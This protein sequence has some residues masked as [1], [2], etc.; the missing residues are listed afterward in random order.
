MP[1]YVW[2]NAAGQTLLRFAPRDHGRS[3]W[4]ESNMVTRPR[5]EAAL[6]E[7]VAEFPNVRVLR[8][9]EAVD[10]RP[11]PHQ[12]APAGQVAV[13]GRVRTADGRTA[14]LD[15]VV[16]PGFRLLVDGAEELS[17]SAGH[18]RLLGDLEARIVPVLPADATPAPAPA[19]VRDVDGMLLPFLRA[20]GHRVQLVRPDGYVFGGAG[21]PQA[22]PA[23][24]D[25]LAT[26]LR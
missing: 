25:Q 7:R 6:C 26:A 14:L 5:L 4:P 17:L 19:S 10:L 21:R 2:R 18:T 20:A 22:L 1:D 15:D 23:L 9:I 12:V 13:Q 11:A 3:G 24:L 16:G 8:G